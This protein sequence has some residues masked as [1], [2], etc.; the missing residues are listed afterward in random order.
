MKKIKKEQYLDVGCSCNDNYSQH[1]GVMLYSM[2]KNCSSPRR[3]KIWLADGGI[4]NLNKQRIKEIVARFNAKINFVIPDRKNLKDLKI[5]RHLGIET[6]YRFYLIENL[7]LRKL[8][9]LDG[10]MVVEGNILEIFDLKFKNNIFFAVKDPGGS[11]LRK[12]I[13]NIPEGNPYFNA[14]VLFIDCEKW[15]KERITDKVIKYMLNNPEKLEFADQDGLNA[16]AIGKW[17]ELDPSWNIITRIFYRKYMPWMSIT[18]FNEKEIREML[19]KPRVI[20]YAGLI[21]PW[22]FFDFHPLKK[23]YWY[24]LKETPWEDYKYPDKSISGMAKRARSYLKAI[25]E[26]HKYIKEMKKLLSK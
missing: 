17:S 18:A 16:L 6:Y 25:I 1:L 12:K 13:F 23:R 2:L 15:R 5:C 10:D 21:K 4:S 7:G 9:Y 14:G 11:E 22:F 19:K 20:H 8:L 24:Y 3:I 26:K